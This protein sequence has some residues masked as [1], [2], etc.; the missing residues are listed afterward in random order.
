L[1]TSESQRQAYAITVGLDGDALLGAIDAEAAPAWLRD[2][3][4]VKTLRSSWG[5]PYY[6]SPEG[7][8]WRTAAEGIPP[9]TRMIRS[10]HDLDARYAKKYTTSWIGYKMPVTERCETEALQLITPVD[11]TAGPIAAGAVTTTI[12]AALQAQQRWPQRHIVETGYRDAELL[13]TSQRAYGVGLLGPTRPDSRWQARAGQGF[14]AGS[15]GID[16]ERR[17]ATCPLGRQSRSWTPVIA[18]R[19]HAVI[20]LKCAPHD[21]PSCP[22]RLACTRA[23]RR[24]ISVR[25]QAP[26]LSLQAA[27]QREQTAAYQAEYAKRARI[28]GTLSHAVRACGLRR[29]RYV[30]AAKT[31]LQHVL[32]AAAINF[33]R[34]G[35]WLAGD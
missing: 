12:H 24:P 6:R 11:T 26:Y 7:P 34:L 5:Q 13:R 18:G 14:D 27:R 21:C 30:G 25:P 29:A 16:G 4:A 3:P 9:A 35:R 32:T 10:P 33:I 15:V 28:E 1:P 8:R 20:K 17:Q 2:V 22:R 31:H 23:T 19:D